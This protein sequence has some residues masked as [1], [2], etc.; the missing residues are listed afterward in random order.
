MCLRFR[1]A[2]STSPPKE[3]A[4]LLIGGLVQQYLCCH[5]P[6]S[7]CSFVAGEEGCISP[8]NLLHCRCAA[9]SCPFSCCFASLMLLRV[10][11]VTTAQ[12]AHEQNAHP[13][14]SLLT[15]HDD[16]E[17][18]YPSSHPAILDI[19]SG[20]KTK[21]QKTLISV[22]QP[23]TYRYRLIALM[24]GIRSQK[25]NQSLGRTT[26][27]YRYESRLFNHVSCE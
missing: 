19:E 26:C 12:I 14:R 10:T 18:S 8:F 21:I 23:N 1:M 2:S 20:T 9:S 5:A 24:D 3:M 22:H 17:S 6:Q 15:L 4:V 13:H 27:C 7:C 16:I 11:H 25:R